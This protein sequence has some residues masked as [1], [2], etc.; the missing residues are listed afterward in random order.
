MRV[1]LAILI[2][3]AIATTLATLALLRIF[4][5]DT[6]V[7]A[8]QESHLERERSRTASALATTVS[9]RSK[10]TEQA[11][12]G[13]KGHGHDIDRRTN[14][15]ID[16]N[17]EAE[18]LKAQLAAMTVPLTPEET[19]L[20]KLHSPENLTT[21]IIETEQAYLT[22]DDDSGRE[23]YKKYV[24]LLNLRAKLEPPPDTP[25]MTERQIEHYRRYDQAIAARRA[26]LSRLPEEEASAL[27]S[28]IK[29]EI[30]RERPQQ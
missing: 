6:Q 7:L 18:R 16:S 11:G 21:A 10:R 23:I 3:T 4:G 28:S 9:E 1:R 13:E 15:I 20:L 2:V 14:A 30:F 12:Q 29:E 22:A 26:E 5:K 19:Q 24:A 17:L 27:R 8:K 25:T